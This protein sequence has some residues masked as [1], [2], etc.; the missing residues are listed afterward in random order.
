MSDNEQKDTKNNTERKEHRP[1]EGRRITQQ[2]PCQQHPP[3]HKI[4][5]EPT[6]KSSPEVDTFRSK[7]ASI[8]PCSVKETNTRSL[9]SK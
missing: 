2:L 1:F 3:K 7:T 4:K 9:N 6:P 8:Q 5:Y